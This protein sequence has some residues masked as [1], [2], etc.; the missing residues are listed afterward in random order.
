MEEE[1]SRQIL[2]DATVIQAILASADS[3]GNP[4]IKLAREA[5][6]RILAACHRSCKRKIDDVSQKQADN[7]SKETEMRLS[8]LAGNFILPFGKH[9]GQKIRDVP[10]HYLCWL[11]GVKRQKRDFVP[12]PVDSNNYIRSR[13]AATLAN[14]QAY[15]VWRCWTCGSQDVSFKRAQLCK[16][17]WHDFH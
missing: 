9:A 7:D 15:L 11:M 6:S 13:Q 17:C 12:V 2:S 10:P 16:S 1:L 5:N 14:V 4:S 3:N 8:G